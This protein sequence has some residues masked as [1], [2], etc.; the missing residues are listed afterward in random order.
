MNVGIIGTGG[1]AQSR[2]RKIAALQDVRCSWIAS[3]NIQQAR[4]LIEGLRKDKIQGDDPPEALGDWCEALRRSDADVIIV[5]TPNTLH[6]AMVSEALKNGK[7]VLVEYPHAVTISEGAELLD[8]AS[9]KKL[10]LHVGLTNRYGGLHKSLAALF[11]SD[12]GPVHSYHI[13]TCSGNP[14]SRWYNQDDLSGG[15]FVASLYHHIEDALSLLGPVEEVSSHYQAIRDEN[16]IISQ[17]CGSAMLVFK[18]E[19]VAQLTYARGHP[20]PG[21]GTVFHVIGERG[22]IEVKGG[23]VYVRTSEGEK[24]VIPDNCDTVLCDTEEFIVGV[25]E[26][27]RSDWSTDAAQDALVVAEHASKSSYRGGRW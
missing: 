4:T 3:R 22:Y 24:E 13:M 18:S 26:G 2:A 21:L 25:K 5:A 27:N 17:D 14:I 10:L 12:V 9:S 20:K 7:H 6:H 19:C 23:K 8:I 16:G 1:M 15:F 11:A